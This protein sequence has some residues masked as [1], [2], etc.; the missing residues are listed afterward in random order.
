MSIEITESVSNDLEVIRKFCIDR[1][2]KI[3]VAESASAGV[4]QLLLSNMNEAGLFFNGGITTYT[5]EMKQH[6][7][8]IP[9]ETCIE[10][11]GVTQEI[12][13]HMAQNICIL[14]KS[15]IGISLTGYASAI[16]EQQIF[17]KF[18]LVSI[19]LDGKLILSER[20]TS[21]KTLQWE[22]Q[23]DFAFQAIMLAQGV[24]PR[25][26]GAAGQIPF[27]RNADL[28]PVDR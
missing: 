5:C 28:I 22:V 1:N 23:M 14:Y 19:C 16:P 21:D 27:D 4:I 18:S 12:T 25:V 2:L 15:D 9:L 20:L 7:L 24:F 11:N 17:D 26:S 3:A 6:L 10:S 13:D 8:H